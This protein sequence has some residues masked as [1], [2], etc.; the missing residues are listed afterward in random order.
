[1][2]IVEYGGKG[3]FLNSLERDYIFAIIERSL[4]MKDTNIDYN[5]TTLQPHSSTYF[6]HPVNIKNFTT[7]ET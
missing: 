3:K 4:H 2:N 7:Q 5:Y 1:M 6:P